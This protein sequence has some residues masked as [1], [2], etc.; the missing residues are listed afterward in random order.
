MDNLAKP[1]GI[2]TAENQ[3][4]KAIYHFLLLPFNPP[5]EAVAC[6]PE[7]H[8]AVELFL[9]AHYDE[10]YDDFTDI[11]GFEKW[12]MEKFIDEYA[13]W[14]DDQKSQVHWLRK[15][16]NHIIH[17]GELDWK[18][19]QVVK[20]RLRKV[21]PIAS[22]LYT[23]LG[24]SLESSVFTTLE[25]QLLRGQEPHW[26]GLST[27]LSQ[28]AIEYSGIDPAVSV[29]ITN[30]AFEVALRGFAGSWQQEGA[31]TLPIPFLIT[32]MNE[33]SDESAPYYYNRQDTADTY[34][35]LPL[36][37]FNKTLSE[38]DAQRQDG[39]VHNA[40]YNYAHEVHELVL[41]Y[42]ERALIREGVC[43]NE[44]WEEIVAELRNKAPDIEIPEVSEYW[45]NEGD[46]SYFLGE[47]ITIILDRGVPEPA[48]NDDQWKVFYEVVEDVCGKLPE[49]VRIKFELQ[50]E[51]W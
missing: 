46:Y 27:M 19:S 39:N 29:D 41:S 48:W 32:K 45:K 43:I 36:E 1:K 7:L 23:E 2:F 10:H 26:K 31:E 8:H 47:Q 18:E 14:N 33:Y 24:Y 21:L 35:E 28:A 4:K 5:Y 6:I 34:R 15:R 38:L 13:N 37:G 3:L 30:A 11:D 16:R 20:D 22:G 25:R 49:G 9:C 50:L 17:E 44:R 40:A 12:G 42:L 51:L